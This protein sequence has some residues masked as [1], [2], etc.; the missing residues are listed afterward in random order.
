MTPLQIQRKR[1]QKL[2]NQ[3]CPECRVRFDE[4]STFVKFAV[5]DGP[6]AAIPFSEERPPEYWAEMLDDNARER[7]LV[8]SGSLRRFLSHPPASHNFPATQ[9]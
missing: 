6:I 2:V 5:Y 1:I 7:L 4:Q 8:L 3:M 9:I